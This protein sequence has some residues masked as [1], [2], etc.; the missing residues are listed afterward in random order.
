MRVIKDEYNSAIFRI[1]MGNVLLEEK[2]YTQGNLDVSNIIRLARENSFDH[3][4]V[5]V[6][7]EYKKNFNSFLKQGFYLTDTLVRYIHVFGE[8]KLPDIRSKT[9]IRDYK[10]NDV[11]ALMAIAKSSFVFDR[12]HSDKSL[13]GALSDKYYE[14]WIYNSCNGFADKVIVSEHNG[15][16]AGF[17]TGKND[18]AD[19]YGHLVLSAVSPKFR[20]LGIYTSMIYK[21][22]QWIAD[23]GYEGVI[24]GTQINNIA[25]Q[26]AWIKLGFTV[27]DSQYILH[28]HL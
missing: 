2:E 26:K 5:K 4:S 22:I 6:P 20:G 7:T 28:M 14:R 18:P 25:V 3:L 21:G 11:D 24:V 19:R 27:L 23:E 1:Q 17:T 13:D 8:G 10:P 15:E 12:F 9:I 16:V